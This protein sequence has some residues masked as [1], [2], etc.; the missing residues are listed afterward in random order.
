LPVALGSLIQNALLLGWSDDPELEKLADAIKKY[1]IAQQRCSH[2]IAPSRAVADEV[3]RRND[4]VGRIAPSAEQR[5]GFYVLFTFRS[6]SSLWDHCERQ[7]ALLY[8]RN[9]VN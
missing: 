9:D 7:H 1:V 5:Q 6:A 8:G 3:C 2:A 4:A